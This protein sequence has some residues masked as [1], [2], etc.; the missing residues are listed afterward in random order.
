MLLQRFPFNDS[1]NEIT[2]TRGCLQTNTKNI[3]TLSS[4]TLSLSLL[5]CPASGSTTFAFKW[6]RMQWIIRKFLCDLACRVLIRPGQVEPK[7]SLVLLF[8]FQK[9]KNVQLCA[10]SWPHTRSMKRVPPLPPLFPIL[11]SV[12]GATA[13]RP[14]SSAVKTAFQVQRGKKRRMNKT[15]GFRFLYTLAGYI[16]NVVD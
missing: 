12:L 15:F 9:G 3:C 2:W 11:Y 8:R 5:P 14:Q 7:P 13:P 4:S 6:F 16:T 10:E 1:N